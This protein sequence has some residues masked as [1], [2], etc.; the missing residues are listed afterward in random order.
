[1]LIFTKYGFLSV[2]EDPKRSDRLIIRARFEED[3]EALQQRLASHMPGTGLAWQT[4]GDKEYPYAL[5]CDRTVVADVVAEMV[6]EIDYAQPR[7]S[8]TGHPRRQRDYLACQTALRA[9]D[10]GIA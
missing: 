8:V 5:T 10:K 4:T 3:I 2:A 7:Q 1:M 6:K 9:A